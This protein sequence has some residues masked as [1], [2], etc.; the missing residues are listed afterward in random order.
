MSKQSIYLLYVQGEAQPVLIFTDEDQAISCA[1]AFTRTRIER[2]HGGNVLELDPDYIREGTSA[3]G[4]K[5]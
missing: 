5:N 4:H 1:S 2:W 3:Y